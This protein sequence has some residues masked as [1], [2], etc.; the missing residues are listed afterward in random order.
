ML[1]DG[2]AGDRFNKQRH[3]PTRL[4]HSLSLEPKQVELC[5]RGWRG[6]GW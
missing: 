3:L 1:E 2:A 6:E 4:V 5:S